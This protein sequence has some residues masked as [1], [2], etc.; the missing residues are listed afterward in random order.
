SIVEGVT[1]WTFGC[2]NSDS[3]AFVLASS[4][5]LGTM[6]TFRTSTTGDIAF[7]SASFVAYA[8]ICGGTTSAGNLQSVVSAGTSGQ[9][10]TSNGPSMLPTWQT[11]SS[12]G[13][14]I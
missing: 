10:L 5:S 6:N 14:V 9:V 13:G 1:T 12:G 3:D 7:P 4:A 11:V 2:D 8:P